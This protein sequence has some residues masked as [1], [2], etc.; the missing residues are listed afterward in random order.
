MLEF[1]N[2]TM[3]IYKSDVTHTLTNS[4]PLKQHRNSFV[5]YKCNLFDILDLFSTVDSNIE[6]KYAGTF[7][8]LQ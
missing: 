6:V 2:P 5:Q 4:L 7:E 3:S 1:Y 8:K